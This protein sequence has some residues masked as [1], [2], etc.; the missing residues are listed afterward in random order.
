MATLTIWGIYAPNN[1]DTTVF[2][3]L[4]LPEGLNREN[5]IKNI[6]LRCGDFELSYPDYNF[7]R[8]AVGAW[9]Y[10]YKDTFQK[11]YDIMTTEY[12]PIENYNREETM[13]EDWAGGSNMTSTTQDSKS[14]SGNATQSH[15]S[16]SNKHRIV[17]FN[18]SSNN[19]NAGILADENLTE[20]TDESH[21]SAQDV[22][23]YQESGGDHRETDRTSIIK[24]NIGVTTSQQMIESELKLREWNLIDHI[25]DL[26]VAEFCL[27]VY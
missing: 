8:E 7:M 9:S 5:T 10:K 1:D 11:W 3:L 15:G 2:D 19:T 21:I 20:Y 23:Q 13:S 25:A 26:F 18:R 27:C 16:G 14:M 12:N 24:G 17:P 4:E 22:M 6:M